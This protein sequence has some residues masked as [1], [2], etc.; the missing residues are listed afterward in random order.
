MVIFRLTLQHLQDSTVALQNAAQYVSVNG[1]VLI[2][3]SCDTAHRTSH[4]ISAIDEALQLV[5]EAQSSKGKGNR[6]ITL[7][8]LQ[9]L[10]SATSPLGSLY[11]VVFSNLDAEGNILCDI[12]RF[13]GEQNRRLFFN[14]GL[15]FLTLLHR[16]YQIPVDLC[17]GYHELK[18]YVADK[19][20]WTSLGSHCLVLKR[21]TAAA[22]QKTSD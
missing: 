3:D 22:S 4:P 13:E 17:K 1:Y 18:A 11:E 21:K 12:T 5:A 6:R 19:G 14:H 20:A 16:T 8:L 15:L 2:I 7:E 10:E 9:G